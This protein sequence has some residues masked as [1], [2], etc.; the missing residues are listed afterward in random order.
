MLR[1]YSDALFIALLIFLPLA[2]GSVHAWSITLF[3]LVAVILFNSAVFHPDFSFKKLFSIPVVIMSV[4]FAGY[5]IFQ[6]V[7]LPP[8]VL[9]VFS[10]NT[11][12]FYSDFSL[13]YPWINSWRS[14]SVYPWLTI[15]EFIKIIACGLVF[16]FILFRTSQGNGRKITDLEHNTL[17]YL[18]LGCLT[19]ILAILLHSLV[20]FNL[21]ITANAL[22]FT[23]LLGLAVAIDR[24][25]G[26]D[27][28]FIQ[29]V[30]NAI[31]YIGFAIALFGIA[32]KLSGST[33]IYWV[34]EKDGSHF[35]PYVNYDHYAGFMGMCSSLALASFMAKV[36]YSSFFRI[37]GVKDKL[38]WFSTQEASSALRQFFAVAVMVGS[39]FYSSSRGG[40]LSFVMAALV[41]YFLIIIRT[42]K[43]RRGRL[44]FFFVLLMLLSG[45][46]TFWIGPDETF[47][48]FHQLNSVAR[49]VIHESSVL[50]EM[51]PQMWLDAK[52]IIRDFPVTGTGFGTFQSI[53]PKYRTHEWGGRVLLYTHCDYLQLI[54]ET[55]VVGM[56]FIAAFLVYFARLYAS[57]LRKLR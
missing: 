57:A 37:K 7:P 42:R 10:P 20:D 55:G 15:W 39:I 45:V 36:R 30:V 52:N 28:V 21:H 33:K 35:G 9:K 38:M 1:R 43:S 25:E 23:V 47:E 49:S 11:Y 41:F 24:E 32:H 16:L 26:V 12:K 3:S 40:I 48:R 46:F 8:A 13:I 54:S 6:L 2:L 14:I 50:S 4:V 17:V 5:V 18:K 19:G 27:F 31:I 34:I 22:Y 56:F 29:K 51:R 44:L 53:F